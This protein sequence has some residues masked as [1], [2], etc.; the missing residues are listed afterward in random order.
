M[1]YT[2]IA[3]GQISATSLEGH[4]ETIDCQLLSGTRACRGLGVK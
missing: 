2:F 4:D 1:I 3:A